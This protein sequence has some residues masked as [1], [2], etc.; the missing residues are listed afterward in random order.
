MLS[1]RLQRSLAM[2][3]MCEATLVLMA[4]IR[5]A[6]PVQEASLGRRLISW[7]LQDGSV[8]SFKVRVFSEAAAAAQA[9]L[10]GASA[11]DVCCSFAHYYTAL[12]DLLSRQPDLGQV[13]D[14]LLPAPQ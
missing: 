7:A 9:G 5:H 13:T 14:L 4:T 1:I 8:A 10:R 3:A 2:P 12:A 11:G 6:A